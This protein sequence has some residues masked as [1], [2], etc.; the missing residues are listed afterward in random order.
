MGVEGVSQ[1]IYERSSSQTER[2]AATKSKVD[3][4]AGEEEG[5]RSKGSDVIQS[6]IKFYGT[7]SL[8]FINHLVLQSNSIS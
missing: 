5:R 3:R 2:T 1:S 6:D 7:I 8:A 4:G